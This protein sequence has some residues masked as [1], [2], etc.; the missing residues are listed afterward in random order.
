MLN[1]E[2]CVKNCVEKYGLTEVEARRIARTDNVLLSLDELRYKYDNLKIGTK[3]PDWITPEEHIN[4][5]YKD[6]YK[7][8]DKHHTWY[9]SCDDVAIE[10]FIYSSLFIHTYTNINQLNAF[11]IN[12]MKN[13]MRDCRQDEIKVFNDTYKNI[14][15]EDDKR[16]EQ[17]NVNIQRSIKAKE[18]FNIVEL[19][20][21]VKTIKDKKIRGILIL[22]AFCIADISEFRD[23]VVDI[24]NESK[25]KIQEKIYD[26]CKFDKEFCN[27]INRN[28]EQL[29]NK[30]IN[31][32]I[33]RILKIFGERNKQYLST[34]VLPCLS[35]LNL[36]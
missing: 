16:R 15:I 25:P 32:S 14:Q 26:L 19:K 3:Y 29:K 4:L 34:N 35:K 23:L 7:Y 31:I 30:K 5:C 28:C 2:K 12:R 17:L 22:T 33:G 9:E 20:E 27:S 24:Y 13:Y 18:D 21:D 6:V 8:Y 11:I 1:I 10:L 36:I